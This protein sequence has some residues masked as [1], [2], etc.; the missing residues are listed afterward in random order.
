VSLA[1]L[2]LGCRVC[3]VGLGMSFGVFLG[4][5][6]WAFFFLSSL[7]SPLPPY[8]LCIFSV[9]QGLHPFALLIYSTDFKKKKF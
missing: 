9:Y 8:P 4:F 6:G 2:F 5:L 1:V 3:F 7:S